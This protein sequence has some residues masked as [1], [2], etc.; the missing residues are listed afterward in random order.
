MIDF[1]VSWTSNTH[2]FWTPII[3][4]FFNEP[5]KAEL[6]SFCG[7]KVSMYTILCSPYVSQISLLHSKLLKLPKGFS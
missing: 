4:W 3:Y 2:R 6:R 7:N 5:F 1:L